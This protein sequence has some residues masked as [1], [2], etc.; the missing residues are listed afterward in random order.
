MTKPGFLSP[1]DEIVATDNRQLWRKQPGNDGKAL[2][3]LCRWT[4]REFRLVTP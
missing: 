2:S 4:P 1:H 3:T